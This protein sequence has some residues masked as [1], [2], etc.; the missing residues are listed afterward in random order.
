MTGLE[1][2]HE[3]H[4]SLDCDLGLWKHRPS[5]QTK[6]TSNRPLSGDRHVNDRLTHSRNHEQRCVW[7]RGRAPI[8][9]FDH[10]HV[11][12]WC[13]GCRGVV[14]AGVVLS[15]IY[16]GLLVTVP[17]EMFKKIAFYSMA[18]PCTIH[19][20]ATACNFTKNCASC[21]EHFRK[22]AAWL[23]M[24]FACI[25]GITGLVLWIVRYK[26]EMYNV[27][28]YLFVVPPILSPCPS[29]RHDP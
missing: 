24:S 21:A 6:R 27:G 13:R 3:K 2:L 18:C 28:L 29:T 14:E 22:Y 4:A 25:L 19:D 11:F 26:E 15:I 7:M 20:P 16:T 17:V 8:P 23:I 9:A 10:R 12:V 5:L 1:A